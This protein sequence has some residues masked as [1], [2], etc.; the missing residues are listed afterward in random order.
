M[1][2]LL[3][4][5]D[6]RSILLVT[7]AILTAHGYDVITASDGA[8]AVAI[9][10]E[11]QSRIKAVITDMAMPYMDGGEAIRAIRKLNPQAKLVAVSGFLEYDRLVDATGCTGVSILQKPYSPDKLLH[12]LAS[13]LAAN[14]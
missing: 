4:V 9:Y 8:E 13:V 14:G 7:Q 12:T 1:A 11:H 6:E 3:V 10:K 5:D 2:R